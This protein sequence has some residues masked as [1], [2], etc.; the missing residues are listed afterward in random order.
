MTNLS[1]SLPEALIAYLQ[2]QLASGQYNTTDDYIQDLI[3]QDKAHNDVAKYAE[4]PSSEMSPQQYRQAG[5]MKGMFTMADDFD[6]PL[7]DLNN[8]M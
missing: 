6:T 4:T 8:S 3:Q 5:T 1:I 2:E 7:E